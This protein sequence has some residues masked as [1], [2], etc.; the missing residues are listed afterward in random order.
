MA[1]ELFSKLH[2]WLPRHE[3][4]K[5]I[6]YYTTYDSITYAALYILSVTNNYYLAGHLSES[7]YENIVQLLSAY[8]PSIDRILY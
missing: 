8:E 3:I 5:A 7:E 4:S 1:H 2:R 6:D